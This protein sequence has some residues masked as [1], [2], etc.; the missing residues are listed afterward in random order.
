[1]ADADAAAAVAF[2]DA[3]VT[4][5][6]QHHGYAAGRQRPE[7]THE[8]TADRERACYWAVLCNAR[9]FDGSGLASTAGRHFWR[10]GPDGAR[11]LRAHGIRLPDDAADGQ[12]RA[13]CRAVRRAVQ[14]A[15]T[16]P[17]GD[18]KKRPNTRP[19]DD[20]RCAGEW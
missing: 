3:D 18:C 10:H 11:A 15:V 12:S 17:F 5:T 14:P 1:H 8:E 4:G 19:A 7:A 13:G 20:G 6:R 2:D 16:D 9:C